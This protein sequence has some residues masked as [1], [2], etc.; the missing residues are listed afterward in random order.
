VTPAGR[1]GGLL[2]A[3]GGGRRFGGAKALAMLEGRLL[4]ERG[5]ALLRAGGCTP[6]VVVLGAEAADVIAAADLEGAD[7][8]VNPHWAQGLGSSLRAGLEALEGTPAGAVIIALVDQPLIDPV[9]V[10]RLSEAWA[11]GAVAAVATYGG[12]PRNPVLLDR[13]LWAPARAQTGGDVGA[14]TLL[15]GHPELVT[16]V[17][18]DDAGDPFDVDTPSALEAVRAQLARR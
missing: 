5:V 7:V 15:R 13:A 1:V 14:R 4:V 8:V 17:A 6:L 3:A 11:A 12:R 18:C 9:A 2:L 10:R 16:R